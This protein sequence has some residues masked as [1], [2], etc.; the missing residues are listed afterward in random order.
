MIY[1]PIFE[2]LFI[3]ISFLELFNVLE[4]FCGATELFRL[5]G[6]FFFFYLSGILIMF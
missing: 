3:T 2:L 4:I 1:E 6:N 5:Y